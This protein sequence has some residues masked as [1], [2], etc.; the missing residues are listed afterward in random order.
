MRPP[1]SKSRFKS[2]S[3][4][5]F[6]ETAPPKNRNSDFQYGPPRMSGPTRREVFYGE[7][8]VLPQRR[9]GRGG[10][11]AAER[12]PTELFQISVY[13]EFA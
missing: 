8:M 4:G 13:A 10:V 7:G 11:A 5:G 6:I 2:F 1:G 3:A 12:G 9:R